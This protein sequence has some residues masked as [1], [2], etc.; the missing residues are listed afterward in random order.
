MYKANVS[1]VFAKYVH[2]PAVVSSMG[3]SMKIGLKIGMHIG[4]AIEGAIGSKYKIDACMLSPNVNLA[5]RL[6]S[7]ANQYKVDLILSHKFVQSLSASAR[8]KCRKIDCVTVEE[9]QL[10]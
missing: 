9:A 4:W 2:N 10:L 6:A 8:R 5:A 1:G 7:A 3:S